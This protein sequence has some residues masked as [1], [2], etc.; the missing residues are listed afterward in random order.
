[1]QL[2]IMLN[3]ILLLVGIY[4]LMELR[5]E[6]RTL[7]ATKCSS[8]KLATAILPTGEAPCNVW[9]HPVGLRVA[10][11]TLAMGLSNKPRVLHM[12]DIDLSSAPLDSWSRYMRDVTRDQGDHNLLEPLIVPI[13]IN[14]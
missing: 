3:A 4:H 12:P 9:K 6:A 14:R 2:S 7:V 11:K 1:M 5:I 8:V 13:L 10:S